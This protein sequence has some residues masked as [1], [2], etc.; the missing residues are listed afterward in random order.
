MAL[1]SS[2]G[3]TLK[4]ESGQLA[5]TSFGLSK[6]TDTSMRFHLSGHF[7]QNEQLQAQHASVG[8]SRNGIVVVRLVSVPHGSVR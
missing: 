4:A 2:A 6:R 7:A 5:L 1:D 8:L 3:R